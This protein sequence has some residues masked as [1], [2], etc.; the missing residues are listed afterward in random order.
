MLRWRIPNF[1]LKTD[2][3]F[4]EQQRLYCPQT[5]MD[6]NVHLEVYLRSSVEVFAASAS[7][8]GNQY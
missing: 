3:P 2:F 6:M 7:I 5:P 1:E 4:A 8:A